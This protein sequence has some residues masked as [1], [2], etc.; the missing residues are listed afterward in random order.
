M[1]GIQFSHPWWLLLALPPL[2]LWF[3]DRRRRRN[4][5]R[6]V[7]FSGYDLVP[8]KRNTRTAI[9]GLFSP[10]RCLAMISVVPVVA[11][12]GW[13]DPDAGRAEDSA[14]VIVLDISSSMTADDFGTGG[15]LEAAKKHLQQLVASSPAAELGTVVFAAAPRLVVPV[16]GDHGAVSEALAEI[17]PVEFGQDGTAIGTALASAINRLR[18][19]SWQRREVLLLTDGVNNSGA[20]APLDAARLARALGIRINTIGVGGDSPS[21]FW[22]PSAEGAPYRMEAQIEID[23][24]TLEDAARETGGSYTRVKDSGQLSRALMSFGGTRQRTIWRSLFYRRDLVRIL[25]LFALI[26]LCLGVVLSNFAR[27]ELPD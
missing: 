22:V 4:A 15:R 9:S 8:A 10:L 13:K 24:K 27:P 12:I 26:V 5:A 7:A 2:I 16:T 11:G 19:G 25:A 14:L 1:S 21:H 18:C 20:I 17:Q 23:E 6:A 3:L